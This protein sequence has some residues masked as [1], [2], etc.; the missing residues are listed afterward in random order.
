MRTKK[1]YPWIMLA[2][3]VAMN[4]VFPGMIYNTLYVYT[5]TILKEFPEFSRSAFVFAVTLGN[6]VTAVGNLVYEPIHRKVGV[7]G[8]IIFGAVA[9]LSGAVIF[10]YTRVH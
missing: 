2:C 1:W 4:F 7:R 9:M 10:S 8:M 5:P 6:L 3:A